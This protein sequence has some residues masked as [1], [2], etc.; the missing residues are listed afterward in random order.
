MSEAEKLEVA[1]VA[2][3]K[4]ELELVAYGDLK[5]EFEARGIQNVFKPGTKKEVLITLAI[6]AL[7][8]KD[9]PEDAVVETPKVETGVVDTAAAENIVVNGAETVTTK[10]DEVVEPVAPKADETVEVEKEKEPEFEKVEK[11]VITGEPLYTREVI[12]ENLG[13]LAA[14]LRVCTEASRKEIFDKQENLLAHLEYL[15]E[16]E[17]KK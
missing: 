10:A 11:L 12:E 13:I 8:K 7:F 15:N 3:V 1:K 6:E 2:E 17:A 5:K 16:W 14:T 9:V 4:A